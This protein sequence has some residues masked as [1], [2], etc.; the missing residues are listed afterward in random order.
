MDQDTTWL[1][2][3]LSA[4]QI[5]LLVDNQSAIA[6][7][8]NPMYQQRTRHIAVKY[9]WIRELLESGIAKTHYVLTNDQLADLCTKAL[10]KKKHEEAIKQLKIT[11]L[12]Q[13]GVLT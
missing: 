8:T 13:G 2:Q 11:G 3:C 4:E 1:S 5:T 6:L 10:G 12:E 7:S 9:H